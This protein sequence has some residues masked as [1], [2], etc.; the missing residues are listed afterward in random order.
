V[1]RRTP[2]PAVT[3]RVSRS[4][5]GDNEV[6]GQPATD[7]GRVAP[8]INE[9]GDLT[10]R[11]YVIVLKR[12]VRAFSEDDVP[13]L[14][15]GVAF[16]IFLSLLPSLL[17]AMALYGLFRTPLEIAWQLAPLTSALPDQASQLLRDNLFLLAEL[18]RST[19]RS[20]AIFGIAAGL[21]SAT[22]AAATLI[23][24][25]NRAYDIHDERPWIAQRLIGLALTGALVVALASLVV[26][27]VAGPAAQNLLLPRQLEVPVVLVPLAVGRWLLALG[28]LMV[29]FAFV[30]WIAPNRA[31]PSWEWLSPG[32]IIGVAGWILVTGGFRLYAATIGRESFSAT[33]SAYGTIGGVIILLL[34][35]QLSM[36]ATLTGA[37]LNAEVERLR[38]ER[39]L[40]R[41]GV[42]GLSAV[43]DERP[44]T[45][46]APTD[47]KDATR[48]TMLAAS[49]IDTN[50]AVREL[51][52]GPPG[53]PGTAAP[54]PRRA[55]SLRR[56]LRWRGRL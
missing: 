14:A 17:A 38:T 16:K 6:M 42:L 50:P 32:A 36:L 1:A 54:E 20:L 27:V 41:A 30:Y 35:L 21:F 46:V 53:A 18:D 22:G 5:N 49:S 19:V 37:E 55:R 10:R 9:P 33:G 24:A 12:L 28:V 56:R 31:R 47:V 15:A 52:D 40:D 45:A 43:G 25:L 7:A 2:R 4:E 3:H 34:W 8:A 51:A 29:L 26:L 39:Y 13:G 44:E 11:D 48:Q 23:K